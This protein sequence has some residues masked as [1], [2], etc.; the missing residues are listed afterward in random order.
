MDTITMQV[1]GG[2]LASIAAEMSQKMIRMSF[3]ILIKE[4]EDIG[5]AITDADGNQLAEADTS[6]LQ[7]GPIPFYVRGAKRILAE[8]GEDIRPGDII[9]H[10]SPYHGASHAPDIGVLVPVFRDVRLVAF[11]VTTAHHM[12]IGCAKPGTSVIDA[13]D[14]WAGGLRL[15]ALKVREEGRENIG[16]WRMIADNVRI[17]DLVIG[18]LRAQLAAAEI[19]AA[20]LNELFDEI[21]IDRVFEAQRLLEDYSER[22]LRQQIAALPDGEYRAESVLDGAPDDP[23]NRDLPIVTTLR[24]AGDTLEVDLAGT[25]PQLRNLPFNMP[26]EGTVTCAIYTVI[27]SILLDSEI[28]EWVPQNSGLAR[29]IKISA[30]LGCMANPIFP[31]PTLARAVGG[32]AVADALVRAFAKVVPE[33]A[34]AGCGT[35]SVY[36]YSGL[37][38]DGYWVHMDIHEGSYGARATKDGMDAVDTLYTNT[39]CAPIEEIETAYPLRCRRWM[40]NNKPIG[41]GRFRGGVGGMREFEFLTDGYISSEADGQRHAPVG[42]CGGQDGYPSEMW[43]VDADGSATQLGSKL[44]GRDARKG[45]VF[46]VIAANGG[47][48][49]DPLNRDPDLVLRD[50]RDGLLGVDEARRVYAVVICPDERSIDR[51]ATKAL[52]G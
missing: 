9:M 51:E 34:C 1:I 28:H 14:E 16:I 25:A 19:G 42:I 13:V 11:A 30:P 22:M 38:D 27:R 5:C 47:G 46:R 3:S 15:L 12:D 23:A 31:A 43:L 4:S 26:L 20:R 7:M 10:N 44:T 48:Y 45:Q 35:L 40:L 33:K 32:L 39:R 36:S 49:G 52:R 37:S 50:W 17:P 29:P 41:H 21:G 24:I 2:R 18:D 8:R 6:P